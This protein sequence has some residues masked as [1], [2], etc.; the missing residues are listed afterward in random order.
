MEGIMGT[1]F[2]HWI[3]LVAVCLVAPQW[4]FSQTQISTRHL[5]AHLAAGQSGQIEFETQYPVFNTGAQ[6]VD[7][8]VEF[9]GDDGLPL[10]LVLQEGVSGRNFGS[11]S[12]FTA[13][14]G[15]NAS[16]L[17]SASL[18]RGT[19]ARTGWTRITSSAAVAIGS[20]FD[21][22]SGGLI[23]RVGVPP[24]VSSAQFNLFLIH[25][26]SGSPPTITGIAVANPSEESVSFTAT[27]LD[28][29][30]KTTEQRSFTLGPR[31]HLARFAAELFPSIPSLFVGRV[32]IT[33]NAPL[34]LLPLVA[35]GAVLTSV[36]VFQ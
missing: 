21:L 11:G 2:V 5:F 23:S 18:A 16:I 34:V 36:P 28:F 3:V 35:E 20:A 19:P 26:A 7:L 33:A 17:L 14:V 25:L 10:N 1:K 6:P 12:S 32:A 9:F 4:S 24:G 13:S 8:Q 15:A 31:A 30:G 29:E 22:R 27:L